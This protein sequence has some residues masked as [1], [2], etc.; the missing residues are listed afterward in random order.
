M[1]VHLLDLKEGL[2]IA[3]GA[4]RANKMRSILTALGIFIGILSVTLMGTAIEGLDR[5]FNKSISAIGADVLYVQKWPWGGGQDWWTIRNRKDIRIEHSRA[6]ERSAE[7]VSGVSPIIGTARNVKYGRK[8][9]ENAIIVGTDE[10]FTTTSNVNVTLGRFLTALEVSGGR[11][12]CVLGSEIAEGLFPAETPLGKTVKV[13]GYPYKVVGVLE[14]QGSFLGLQSLDNRVYVPI[15]RFFKE[16]RSFRGGIEIWVKAASIDLVPETKEE[17]RGIMRKARKLSPKAQDDFAINQQEILVQTF[18][19]F[20]VMIAGFGLF[21]TGLSLFVGGIG[22]MNIM[23]VSVTERTREIGIRMA[24]GAPR[25]TIL[26]QFLIEAGALSLIGG[27]AGIAFAFPLTLVINQVLPTAMPLNIV[28]IA[29]LVSVA[30]GVI[31]GF[32]PAYRASRLDPVDALRY[33]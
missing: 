32:L 33:E 30:V 23:F 28:F 1:V 20:G 5:A 16:F 6:I 18:N 8:L 4:I 31:S 24:I 17:I 29:L 2:L 14:K 26:A 13:G 15:N 11:P 21:I 7:L 27:V 22:I 12:I 19:S 10:E 25:R 9:M 3:F